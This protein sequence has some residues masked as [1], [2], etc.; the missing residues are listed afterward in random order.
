MSKKWSKNFPTKAGNYWFYGWRFGKSMDLF[1]KKPEKPE[2]SFVEVH[3]VMNGLLF[4]TRGHCLEKS[5]G[6]EGLWCKAILPE[7]PELD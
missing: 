1:T 3:Q 2:L 5:E 7:L 6:T 4:V